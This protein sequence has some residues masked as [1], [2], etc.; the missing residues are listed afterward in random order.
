MALVTSEIL[1]IE[2]L[3]NELAV[4]FTKP[5]LY[6]DNQS[7]VSLTHNPVLHARTKHMELDVHF[8]REKVVDHALSVELVPAA[9]QTA[10]ILTKPLSTTQFCALRHKRNV[11]S[12]V[13]T[14]CA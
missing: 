9:Y 14:P 8:L 12:P 10:N 7:A 11:C 1:W 2:S 4:P 13:S 3:L 6:C 5:V